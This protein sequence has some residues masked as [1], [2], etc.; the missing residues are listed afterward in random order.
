MSQTANKKTTKKTTSPYLFNI[1]R[2]LSELSPA[3]KSK[4]YRFVI[5]ETG[6]SSRTVMRQKYL[7]GDS[8]MKPNFDAISAYA[9]KLGCTIDELQNK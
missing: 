2:R 8:K 7:R 9:K 6:L 1:L 3:E 4:V 5:K